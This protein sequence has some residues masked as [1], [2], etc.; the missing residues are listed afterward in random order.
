MNLQPTD[1]EKG[2][3]QPPDN[4][5]QDDGGSSQIRLGRLRRGRG[6]V[7]GGQVRIRGTGQHRGQIEG[8]SANT[9]HTR[10]NK[11]PIICFRVVLFLSVIAVFKVPVLT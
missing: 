5:I 3:G 7:A 2:G 9:I 4:A 10:G 6:R 8:A 1:S 11:H